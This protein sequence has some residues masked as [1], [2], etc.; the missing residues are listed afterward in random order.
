MIQKNSGSEGALVVWRSVGK[1]SS[2]DGQS[3]G[4]QDS[5]VGSTLAP[6]IQEE[7]KL[8]NHIAKCQQKM[9]KNKHL[10]KT[11]GIIIVVGWKLSMS[12]LSSATTFSSKYLPIYEDGYIEGFECN[13]VL[14]RNSLCWFFSFTF[15]LI[16]FGFYAQNPSDWLLTISRCMVI[17]LSSAS[18][19]DCQS[20]R[21]HSFTLSLWRSGS[22]C[23]L[24]LSFKS[25]QP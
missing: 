22:W 2:E 15:T 3:L 25:F 6:A 8:K 4:R 16:S 9:W 24:S 18:C 23:S 11:D 14:F 21:S 10:L 7:M 19:S 12:S 1:L 5:A 20:L 13:F 17:G